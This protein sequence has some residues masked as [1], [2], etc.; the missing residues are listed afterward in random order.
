MEEEKSCYCVSRTCLVQANWP[1]AEFYVLTRCAFWVQGLPFYCYY[2]QLMMAERY[3]KELIL[4]LD[5]SHTWGNLT[6]YCGKN[7]TSVFA[8]CWT[9]SG[10]A[11]KCYWKAQENTEGCYY[12]PWRVRDLHK[13]LTS[14]YPLKYLN[15]L[16]TFILNI[17]NFTFPG[18]HLLCGF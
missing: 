11:L 16:I 13:L 9:G 17:I 2:F 12:G 10:N 18:F 4:Y 8:C 5:V 1:F 7:I 14:N 3:P 6:F 15:G